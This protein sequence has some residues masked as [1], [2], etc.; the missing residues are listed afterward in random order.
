MIIE[1]VS[2]DDCAAADDVVVVI[3][4]LRAFSTAAYALAA[5]AQR[6]LLVSAVAEAIALRE[7]IPGALAMGE[8]GGIRAPG[9]DL[10]NSPSEVLARDLRGVTLIHRTSAGTQGVVRAVRARALFG[11]SFVCAAATVHAVLALKPGRVTLVVTGRYPG[12]DGD[13]DAACA[14]YLGALLRGQAPSAGGFLRRVM[15][16]QSAAQFLDPDKPEFPAS[17]LEWCTRLD[18]FAFALPVRRVAGLLE[19]TPA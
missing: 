18:R 5:G 8:V 16:S 19:L 4:V 2:L 17:D 11:A 9:F 13:E 7:R 15:N 10:G 1:T 3:D 12:N 14:D 6:I